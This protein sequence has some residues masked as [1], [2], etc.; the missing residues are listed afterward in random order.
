MISRPRKMGLGRRS[1]ART[2]RLDNAQASGEE[3][4]VVGFKHVHDKCGGGSRHGRDRRPDVQLA[5]TGKER[6]KGRKRQVERKG[7][8]RKVKR[9]GQENVGTCTTEC[10]VRGTKKEQ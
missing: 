9:R 3:V 1:P 6:T 4:R 10:K 5:S 7:G 2:P 8:K